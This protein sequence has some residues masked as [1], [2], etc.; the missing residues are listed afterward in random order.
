MP[1]F[2]LH[3]AVQRYV[4]K[5]DGFDKLATEDSRAGMLSL[6]DSRRAGGPLQLSKF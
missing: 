5:L 2:D 1:S 6:F 4:G 3:I